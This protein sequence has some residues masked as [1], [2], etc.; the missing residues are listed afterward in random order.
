MVRAPVMVPEWGTRGILV[1]NGY[2]WGSMMWMWLS[3]DPSG[4]LLDDDE[5]E[6]VKSR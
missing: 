6:D 4:T 2:F 3:H 1:G 5:E